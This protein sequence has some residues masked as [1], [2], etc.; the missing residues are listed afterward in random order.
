MPGAFRGVIVALS[1]ASATASAETHAN[2]SCHTGP[3]THTWYYA[4]DGNKTVAASGRL[5]GVSGDDDADVLINLGKNSDNAYLQQ[6]HGQTVDTGD[7]LKGEVNLHKGQGGAP[8]QFAALVIDKLKLPGMRAIIKGEWV[9]DHHHDR[10]LWKNNGHTEIH[11]IRWVRA[12]LEDPATSS[13]IVFLLAHDWHA[14]RHFKSTDDDISTTLRVP[15]PDAADEA[16]LSA[17]AATRSR[18]V[19]SLTEQSVLDAGPEQG[20]SG[21]LATHA[22]FPDPPEAQLALTLHPPLGAMP[23]IRPRYPGYLGQFS[24]GSAALFSDALSYQVVT[25]SGKKVILVKVSATLTASPASH[26]LLSATWTSTTN[27]TSFAVLGYGNPTNVPYK[28]EGRYRP[29][30]NPEGLS[31]TVAVRATDRRS[32]D[33]PAP[34]EQGFGWTRTF[35]NKVR[36]Y[37]LAP[38]WIELTSTTAPNPARPGSFCSMVTDLRVAEHLLPQIHWKGKLSWRALPLAFAPVQFGTLSVAMPERIAK[39][40]G[41]PAT[42]AVAPAAPMAG[43]VSVSLPYRFSVDPNDDHLAH[44][45]LDDSRS[46]ALVVEVSGETDLGEKVSAQVEVR[47]MCALPE[48]DVVT[49]PGTPDPRWWAI[50]KAVPALQAA[51]FQRPAARAEE[52]DGEAGPLDP[53]GW[54]TGLDAKGREEQA[55]FLKFAVGAPLDDGDR[56]ALKRLAGR[57]ASLRSRQGPTAKE[58]EELMNAHRVADLGSVSNGL[59]VRRRR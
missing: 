34:A 55:A 26:P 7:V 45:T 20:R 18:D 6:A 5:S 35:F 24:S 50:W 22:G 21:Y 2:D 30:A 13:N 14:C 49:A 33:L 19:G 44:V 46:P 9:V 28:V 37:R 23:Q 40:V 42:T 41:A 3:E 11:P 48:S 4:D 56:A 31:W 47:P 1:L 16:D 38:S 36:R 57:G 27:G 8:G 15:I 10:R 54:G 58:I 59:P 52:P 53:K 12:S 32:S 39:E 29:D 17:P 51:S 43:S 25:E